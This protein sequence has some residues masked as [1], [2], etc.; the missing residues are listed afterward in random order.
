MGCPCQNGKGSSAWGHQL[1][2]QVGTGSFAKQTYEILHG[3]LCRLSAPEICYVV[4]VVVNKLQNS[5]FPL[6]LES[7]GS[8]TPRHTWRYLDHRPSNCQ[9]IKC[10]TR[11]DNGASTAQ[12]EHCTLQLLQVPLVWAQLLLTHVLL[13]SG[14]RVTGWQETQHTEL[15]RANIFTLSGLGS[16]DLVTKR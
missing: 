3:R 16:Q 6:V 14:C 13:G 15:T 1:S 4:P 2:A 5:C 11:W 10:Q 12:K 7:A 8:E 9:G